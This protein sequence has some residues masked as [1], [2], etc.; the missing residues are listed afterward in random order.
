MATMIEQLEQKGHTYRSD[1]S[2]YFKIASMPDYGK[3]AH[4]DHAHQGKGHP[5]GHHCEPTAQNRRHHV[6]AR[7]F[8]FLQELA[9]RL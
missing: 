1:G 9:E 5:F 7:D 6:K 3:L 8:V 4:L 2:V